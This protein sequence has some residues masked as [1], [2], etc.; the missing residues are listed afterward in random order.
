M[1]AGARRG[2]SIHD[3][4][5]VSVKV[6]IA[7]MRRLPPTWNRET[8]R[9]PSTARLSTKHH[10]GRRR[11]VSA[12]IAT[13][14][15]VSLLAW[16]AVVPCSA[17]PNSPATSRPATTPLTA[18]QASVAEGYGDA[19]RVTELLRQN[20]W[21]KYQ[22]A[23]SESDRSAIMAQARDT[24]VHVIA[25]QL[26]P[27]WLGTPWSFYGASEQPG[28]GAIACGYFVTTVLRDAG[29]RVERIRLAQQASE[30][31]IRSL[32]RAENIKRWSNVSIE[33][34]VDQ[35]HHWGPGLYVVGLDNHVGFLLDDGDEVV[36]IHS[37]YREPSQVIK[38]HAGG[39]SI[40]AGSRY[41]VVGKLT[42][43]ERL[44][45]RWLAGEAISTVRH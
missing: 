8:A 11:V 16:N 6:V 14:L 4:L 19:V 7:T 32:V 23:D 17:S 41:R 42:A 27:A 26:L 20:L 37:S 45:R 44:I 13:Q 18:E 25:S 35:V 3:F 29:F 33:T 28:V 5:S 9:P 40:L 39:S 2:I 36:F 30:L 43:D 21:N 22:H 10:R 12:A 34:F 31:I 38:E 24:I 1:L 15:L